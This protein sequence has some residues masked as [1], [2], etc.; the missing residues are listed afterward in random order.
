MKKN[1]VTFYKSGKAAF[2][3]IWHAAPEFRLLKLFLEGAESLEKQINS[4][5]P[6]ACSGKSPEADELSVK[7]RKYL[8]SSNDNL[9]IDMLELSS[10]G[11]FKRK[12]LFTLRDKV[13]PGKVISYSGLAAKAGYEKAARATGTVMSGNPFPLFFPCHRVVKSDRGIGNFGPGVGLKRYLL[14]KEGVVLAAKG[15]VP[16]RYFVK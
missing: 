11:N 9:P 15:A 16:E 13:P 5:Y 8:A 4:Q 1:Y 10:L 12:I 2:A 14:N 6:N 3:L 7:I